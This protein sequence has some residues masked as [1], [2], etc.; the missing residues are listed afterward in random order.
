MT[1]L[2]V[3]QVQA[4]PGGGFGEGTN[5]YVYAAQNHLPFMWAYHRFLGGGGE[6]FVLRIPGPF[7]QFH[8]DIPKYYE[9]FLAMSQTRDT[10][11]WLIK[12]RLPDG[13]SPN[14]DDANLT[15]KYN[16]MFNK[17]WQ[18]GVY[19]W[20]WIDTT[21]PYYSTGS[22]DLAADLICT[23]DDTVSAT[24]PSWPPTQFLAEAGNAVL[25]SDWTPDAIYLLLVGEHGL[26]R[27]SGFGH[28][29][30]DP[31]SFILYAK[32]RLL[33]LDS[34]YINW[35]H[36]DLVNKARNHSLILVDGKGPPLHQVLGQPYGAGSPAFIEDGVDTPFL[37]H[38]AVRTNYAGIRTRR[39]V[40]FADQEYFFVYDEVSS[41]CRHTYEWLLHG[42][43]LE[44]FSLETAGGTWDVDGVRLKAHVTSTQGAP[45]VSS[46]RDANASAWGAWEEHTVLDAAVDARSVKFLSV[47]YPAGPGEAMPNIETVPLETGQAMIAVQRDDDRAIAYAGAG[48]GAVCIPAAQT[49][50]QIVE[51][52]ASVFYLKTGA[53]TGELDQVFARGCT[54]FVFGGRT[55]FSSATR[56]LVT[57]RY[58]DDRIEGHVAPGCGKT[59]SIWTGAEPAAV[60][61]PGV[62]RF[63]YLGCG[64]T[65]IRT[66]GATDFVVKLNPEDLPAFP[67]QDIRKTTD[68]RTYGGAPVACSE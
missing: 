15:Y 57:L 48:L 2:I 55:V 1:D 40:I 64:M 19:A 41:A 63:R 33:A 36:H 17:V 50:S 4:P 53:S 32:G 14:F 38:A 65:R 16:G 45:V 10:I 5:Y 54:R 26:S 68:L 44:T 29:H 52:D 24:P 42:N 27:I 8:L 23:Y 35:E 47:L 43:A 67:S 18:S 22:V 6:E 66:T 51:T 20:D 39:G 21:V 60:E 30:P 61:G 3:N 37:D 12:V 25:R 62:K 13:Q 9:D 31:T 46:H 34:G 49:G 59:L 7:M 11:D 56:V 58:D 28:E